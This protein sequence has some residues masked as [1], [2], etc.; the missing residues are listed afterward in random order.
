MAPAIRTALLTREADDELVSF[1][2]AERAPGR[3]SS[4]GGRCVVGKDKALHLIG[5]EVAV[6]TESLQDQPVTLAEG[7]LQVTRLSASQACNL[8]G[9][10]GRMASVI[11]HR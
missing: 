9:F 1:Q 6:L 3:A 2:A 4:R 8:M 10:R 7:G 5:G 11:R